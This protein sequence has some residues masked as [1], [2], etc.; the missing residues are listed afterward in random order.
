VLLPVLTCSP[1][2]SI[3]TYTLQALQTLFH[4]SQP[5]NQLHHHNGFH[6]R[7]TVHCSARIHRRSAVQR[8]ARLDWRSAVQ[9]YARLHRRS[10]VQ[11]YA[12]LNRRRAVHSHALLDHSNEALGS[13]GLNDLDR[14]STQPMDE[15]IFT[16]FNPLYAHEGWNCARWAHNSKLAHKHSN[17][18]D[19]S[20]FPP[21]QRHST[22]KQRTVQYGSDGIWLTTDVSYCV[23]RTW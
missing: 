12:R 13:C 15:Q 5:T 21:Q 7:S 14:K 8:Y 17:S 23:G 3:T 6:R 18:H 9:C 22:T 16:S 2:H 11:R 1:E 10:A 4:L 20:F 19:L